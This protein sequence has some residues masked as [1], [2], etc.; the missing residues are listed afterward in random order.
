MGGLQLETLN[1]ILAMRAELDPEQARAFDL[2]LAQEFDA[3]SQ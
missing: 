1:H 3:A 2:R